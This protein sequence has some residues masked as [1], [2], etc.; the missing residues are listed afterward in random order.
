[1]N[2]NICGFG[3]RL[4]FS[5]IRTESGPVPKDVYVSSIL[6]G[7]EIKNLHSFEGPSNDPS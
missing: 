3:T 7:T 6:R 2:E 5:L 4:N 1:M